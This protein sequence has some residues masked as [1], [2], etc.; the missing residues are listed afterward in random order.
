MLTRTQLLTGLVALGVAV[1]AYFWWDY[2]RI[3][4][5]EFWSDEVEIA[6]ETFAVRRW[7]GLASPDSPAALRA[8]F[9]LQREIQAAPELNPR[10]PD[11]PEWF[12]CFNSGFIAEALASGE[13]KAY[14]AARNDP[15]G[16]DR[17]VAVLPGGRM[18]MWAQP[19]GE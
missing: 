19:N 4:Y 5:R 13:G 16:Y 17:I 7:Q 10:P 8:C 3:A 9:V 15:P 2:G 12:K 18:F 14:V 1:L 6:G 11:A